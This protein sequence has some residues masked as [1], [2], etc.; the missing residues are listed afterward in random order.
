V[1]IYT[2]APGDTLWLI[3]SKMGVTTQ[4]LIDANHLDPSKY[5]NVGQQL[6]I[7]TTPT[8]PTQ[9]VQKT[10]TVQSGDTLWKIASANGITTQAL[11]TANNLDP[12]KYLSVGQVLVIPSSSTTTPP[13]TTPTQKTYTVQSGDTLWK[14][15]SANGTTTQAL[16]DLNKLD[17]SQYL[18]VGQKLLLP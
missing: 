6:V 12:S 18:Y 15:A 13:A 14:I 10:Y 5:L 11:I 17:P 2:V 9:L 16:I 1:K 4:A 8:T 3:A 7:P